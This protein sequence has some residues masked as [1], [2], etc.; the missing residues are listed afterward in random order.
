MRDH[1]KR[2]R[3]MNRLSNRL[4]LY[5]T[6]ELII[7]VPKNWSCPSA[8]ACKMRFSGCQAMHGLCTIV[9]KLNQNSEKDDCCMGTQSVIKH[10]GKNQQQYSLYGRT[11]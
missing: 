2:G 7:I 3:E 1:I 10:K 4:F 6:H 8:S 5:A 9:L 11:L